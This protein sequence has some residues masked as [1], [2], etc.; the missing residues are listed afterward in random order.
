MI[1]FRSLNFMQYYAFLRRYFKDYNNVTLKILLNGKKL[2]SQP[3]PLPL[4]LPPPP[5]L[6]HLFFKN[7]ISFPPQAS[8][9]A[10]NRTLRTFKKSSRKIQSNMVKERLPSSVKGKKAEPTHQSKPN[11]VTIFENKTDICGDSNSLRSD[12]EDTIS[13]RQVAPSKSDRLF[14]EI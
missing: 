8:S 13:S 3:S 11:L 1:C 12:V 2:I 14:L 9:S 4:P 5:Q 6:S 7:L 10:S